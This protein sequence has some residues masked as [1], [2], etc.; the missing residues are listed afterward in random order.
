MDRRTFLK[1]V[2]GTG[3]ATL[4]VCSGTAIA[5]AEK[6]AGKAGQKN[7][8]LERMGASE[9]SGCRNSGRYRRNGLHFGHEMA[10]GLGGERT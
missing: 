7:R 8:R 2:A 5:V 9:G 1:V 10:A 4:A 6:A 3:A